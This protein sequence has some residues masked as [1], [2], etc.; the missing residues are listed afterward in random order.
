MEGVYKHN[1][2]CFDVYISD[3]NITDS[4]EFL[5]KVLKYLQN[6]GFSVSLKG[7]DKYNRPLVEINGLIHT[8]DK[9]FACCLV[10]R[11]IN[12]KHEVILKENLERYNKIYSF[13]Q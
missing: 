7:F 2:D 9:N 3:K 12:V 8:A 4:D 6:N 13:M 10:E 1:K 5:G 11:F